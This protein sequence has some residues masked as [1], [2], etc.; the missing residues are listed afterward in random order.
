MFNTQQI[1][2]L[3]VGVEAQRAGRFE[4][5]QIWGRVHPEDRPPDSHNVVWATALAL[6][7]VQS[8][9]E[10]AP[11]PGS[12]A[13][14]TIGAH[15]GELTPHT[16]RRPPV[17]AGAFAS[18]ARQGAAVQATAPVAAKRPHPFVARVP[19]ATTGRAAAGLPN[20]ATKE[21]IQPIPVTHR[22]LC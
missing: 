4:S 3:D 5:L 7:I 10:R 14:R 19:L 16:E 21:A 11:T 22:W 12:A 17:P 8:G 6:A 18:F 2:D 13:V 1:L 9:I 20:V 15:L